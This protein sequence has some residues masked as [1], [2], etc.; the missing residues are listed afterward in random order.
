MLH[1]LAALGE[2][3]LLADTL[4]V[5][6][7]PKHRWRL[8]PLA[9]A[10]VC[11]AIDGYLTYI[12]IHCAWADKP[13]LRF[14]NDNTI[15][16]K[17]KN[18]KK[19]HPVVQYSNKTNVSRQ[20]FPSL[21]TQSTWPSVTALFFWNHLNS[22]QFELFLCEENRSSKCQHCHFCVPNKIFWTA[23]PFSPIFH[24]LL[25]CACI[26]MSNCLHW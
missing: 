4:G 13:T 15:V 10:G 19:N 8:K 14:Q 11:K 16:V 3:K 26:S 21:W 18:N 2:Y 22:A 17:K 5:K 9:R 7:S 23:F 24:L 12:L 1:S 20:T 6:G 25:S